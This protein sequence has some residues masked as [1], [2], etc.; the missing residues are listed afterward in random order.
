[1]HITAFC[2]TSV[3]LSFSGEGRINNALHKRYGYT[4]TGNKY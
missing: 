1:M 4:G 2:S 3:T